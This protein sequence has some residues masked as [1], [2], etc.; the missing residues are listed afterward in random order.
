M[1]HSD[2]PKGPSVLSDDG[3]PAYAYDR[4]PFAGLRV[5]FDETR[6]SVTH[7][8]PHQQPDGLS[9][10][11]LVSSEA[12]VQGSGDQRSE[13]RPDSPPATIVEQPPLEQSSPA[14]DVTTLLPNALETIAARE[15]DAQPSA[16]KAQDGNINSVVNSLSGIP[17]VADEIETQAKKDDSNEAILSH[18]EETTREI[19]QEQEQPATSGQGDVFASIPAR[20]KEGASATVESSGPSTGASENAASSSTPPLKEGV[21]TGTFEAATGSSAPPSESPQRQAERTSRQERNSGRNTAIASNKGDSTR[22][23]HESVNVSRTDSKK[24]RSER[25]SRDGGFFKTLK[26]GLRRG[27]SLKKT[28]N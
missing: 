1:A 27:T 19:L 25:S 4:R 16:L 20:G 26:H 13:Q 2:A 12:E 24:E 22:P 8:E 3:K 14:A 11:S 15:E 18:E 9:A 6:S 5:P 10:R 17:R 23:T 28:R 21:G 7:P